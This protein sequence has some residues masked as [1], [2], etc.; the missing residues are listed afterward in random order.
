MDALE[1]LGGIGNTAENWSR[2]CQKIRRILR[3]KIWKICI[4]L[5]ENLRKWTKMMK[6]QWNS[7]RNQSRRWFL[8]SKLSKFASRGAKALPKGGQVTKNWAQGGPKWHQ[9]WLKGDPWRQKW[10]PRYPQGSILE[11]NI[12]R[13]SDIADFGENLGEKVDFVKFVV[14]HK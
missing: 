12:D 2:F 13:N 11:V 5:M 8:D 7:V 10:C 14:L 9:G 3:Q 6:I 4:K 1:M